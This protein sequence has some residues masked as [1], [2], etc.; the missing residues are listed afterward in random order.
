MVTLYRSVVNWIG[1]IAIALNLVVFLII[2]VNRAITTPEIVQV[3]FTFLL[4]IQVVISFI[5]KQVKPGFT[6]Y[7]PQPKYSWAL[8]KIEGKDK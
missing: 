4:A 5:L 7:Q 6:S 2:R 1:F 8:S 3:R